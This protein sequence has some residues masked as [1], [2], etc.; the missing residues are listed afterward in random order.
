MTLPFRHPNRPVPLDKFPAKPPACDVV[1]HD[2]GRIS[3]EYLT[4]AEAERIL[5][6]AMND[7]KLFPLCYAL[8]NVLGINFDEDGDTFHA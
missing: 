3:F 4:R 5:E 7:R 6:L 2:D 8:A 1:E